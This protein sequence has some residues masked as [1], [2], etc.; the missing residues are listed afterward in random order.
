MVKIAFS[1]KCASGKSTAARMVVNRNPDTV[2]MSF[3]AKIKELATE[4]FGMNEKDRPLLLDLGGKMREINEDVWLDYVI[5]KSKTM[6][7][8]VI[9]DLRFPNE[10]KKLK[11]NGF[12]LVRLFVDQETQI[13]RLIKVYPETW[14]THVDNLGVYAETALDDHHFD[15]IVGPEEIDSL[16]KQLVKK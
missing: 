2:I 14:K 7:N 6:D 1:G 16:I 5:N 12:T 4:L 13:K 10:Y 3:A 15:Y 9:D 8:V 11:D